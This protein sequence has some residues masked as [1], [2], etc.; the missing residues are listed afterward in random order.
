MEQEVESP[1]GQLSLQL[2][3]G[4]EAIPL[5]E[6][7]ELYIGQVPQH[8][9]FELSDDPR[10]LGGGPMVPDGVNDRQYVCGIA[11]CREPE[12]AKV[13]GFVVQGKPAGHRPHMP[14]ARSAVMEV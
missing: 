14:G 1:P 5:V 12:N 11:K 9:V 7:N 8:R 2:P 3:D 6:R 10:D 4:G 13:G